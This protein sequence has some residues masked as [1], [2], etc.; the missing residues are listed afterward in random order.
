[1]HQTTVRFTTDLWDQLER[2]AQ[3]MGVSAA[4]YV[5]D[6]TLTRLAYTAGQRGDRVFGQSSAPRVAQTQATLGESE[7]D[8]SAVWEQARLA[9]ERARAVR[10]A[11]AAAEAK[12]RAADLA[13]QAEGGGAT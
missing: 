3:R 13:G 7:P 9:R 11:A 1:M 5:R 12:S 8:A 4:Q 6:A 2:E 10:E